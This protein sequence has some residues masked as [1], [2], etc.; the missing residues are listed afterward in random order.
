MDTTYDL[1]KGILKLAMTSYIETTVERFAAFD[2]SQ[3]FPYRELVGC[4]L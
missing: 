4:L 2:L 1:E 3:G